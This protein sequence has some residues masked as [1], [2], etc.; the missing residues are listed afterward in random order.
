MSRSEEYMQG[1]RAGIKWAI[2]WLHERAKEMNDEHARLILN[3]AAFNMG[4]KAKS[5]PQQESGNT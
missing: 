1:R 4:V 5:A 3:A 2:S